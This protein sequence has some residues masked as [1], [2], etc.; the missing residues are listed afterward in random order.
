MGLDTG[1]FNK[2]SRKTTFFNKINDAYLHVTGAG[3][4]QSS[5]KR[6][7]AARK[8]IAVMAMNAMDVRPVSDNP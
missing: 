6:I 8:S 7:K 2:Q 5:K 1:L 4:L 3:D